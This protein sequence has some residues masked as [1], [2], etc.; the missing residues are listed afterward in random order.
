[1]P[2]INKDTEVIRG[3]GEY[4]LNLPLCIKCKD[5]KHV[6]ECS[7]QPLVANRIDFICEKCNLSWVGNTFSFYYAGVVQ[8]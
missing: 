6:S 3:C 7:T 8:W 5:T 1:M 4:N 2:D